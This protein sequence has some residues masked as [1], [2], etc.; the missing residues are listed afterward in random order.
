MLQRFSY[1]SCSKLTKGV[2]T[3]LDI[4]ITIKTEVKESGSMVTGLQQKE[5][6]KA[7][8]DYHPPKSISTALGWRGRNAVT[9][10]GKTDTF[11]FLNSS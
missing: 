2:G 5:G 8:V 3:E 9:T 1:L 6:K 10:S 7:A 4:W 11:P